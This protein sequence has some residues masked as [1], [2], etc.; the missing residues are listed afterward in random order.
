MLLPVLLLAGTASAATVTEIP[1]FLRGDVEIRYTFDQLAGGLLERAPYGCTG[2][3]DDPCSFGVG[4][5]NVTDHRMTYRF[6]FAP[7]HGVRIGLEL[8]HYVASS[9]KYTDAGEMLLDPATGTGSYEGMTVEGNNVLGYSGAGLGGAWLLIGGTPFSEQFAQ[10]TNYATW[11]LEM[12]VRF[13]DKTDRWT[14]PEGS[15]KSG[16]GYGGTAFR[17]H[18]AFSKIYGASEPYFSFTYQNEGQYNRVRTLQDGQPTL[19]AEGA[20]ACAEAADPLVAT[21]NCVPIDPGSSVDLVFGT[22]LSSRESAGGGKFGADLHMGFG[23]RSWASI[24]GG[25]YLPGTLGVTEGAPIMESESLEAGPG[26]RFD[27]R[28][29]RYMELR[30]GVDARYHLPQRIEN[31]YNVYTDY[32]TVHIFSSGALVVRVR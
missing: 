31:Q 25:S 27:I 22:Q 8:P 32:D 30:L 11:L 19:T 26:L 13:A 21:D 14:T 17:L 5:R 20:D 16:A 9:V 6:T 1:P 18:T 12:G 7:W 29:F 28:F 3:A 15:L 4:R 2:A 10:R 23:Y 24:P